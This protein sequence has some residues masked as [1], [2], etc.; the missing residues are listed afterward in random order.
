MAGFGGSAGQLKRL[1]TLQ[2]ILRTDGT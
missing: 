1:D 2:E